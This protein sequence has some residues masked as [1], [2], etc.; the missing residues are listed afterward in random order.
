MFVYRWDLD[1][2]YLE[3]DFD[4]FRGLVRSA[5]EPASAKRAVPGATAL[6][7]SL[8]DDPRSQVYFIS[9][10]PEQMRS[11][12]VE[13]LRLD[14]VR[15]EGLVLKDS[16]GH[17]RKGQVRAIRGQFGYKMPILLGARAGLGSGVTEMLFGDDAEIDAIVYATYAD[18]VAGR[19]RPGQL[20]RIMEAAG[21]YPEHIDA[22]LALLPTVSTSEAVER[23]FIRLERGVPAERFRPLGGRVVPVH[24]WWQAALVL[25]EL[26]RID[27]GAVEAVLLAVMA[28]EPADPWAIAG[29][30]QALVRNGHVGPEVLEGLSEIGSA[31]DPARRALARLP[32]RPRAPPVI[33]EE[34]VDYVG[35]VKGWHRRR[36]PRVGSE[37]R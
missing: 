6:M 10:S 32:D 26:G 7:R 8:S 5:T 23:I 19:V 11:K 21:A 34:P 27:A 3:T 29:L 13:K 9:G 22:A 24:S 18:V 12:L 16:L 35:I 36:L 14:G 20:S 4:S 33:P 17:L 37:S 15:Y 30:T 2:T 31:L 1:K 25:F 28:E